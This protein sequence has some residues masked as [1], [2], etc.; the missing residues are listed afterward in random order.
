M[1]ESLGLRLFHESFLGDRPVVGIFCDLE[2]GLGG[3]DSSTPNCEFR[4][5]VFHVPWDKT[6][7]RVVLGDHKIH[8]SISGHSTGNHASVRR[9]RLVM[10]V[11][12]EST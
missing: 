6:F 11:S 10:V 1:I 8:V 5:L 9:F 12:N 2:L 3:L 4:I 7:V